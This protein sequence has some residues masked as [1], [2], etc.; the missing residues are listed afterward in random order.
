[1]VGKILSTTMLEVEKAAQ[2]KGIIDVSKY[3]WEVAQF[4]KLLYS[5]IVAFFLAPPPPLPPPSPIPLLLGD[6]GLPYLVP[7][8][9]VCCSLVGPKVVHIDGFGSYLLWSWLKTGRVI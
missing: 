9:V 8:A 1:M 6:H 7:V 2:H 5:T 3:F 4:S